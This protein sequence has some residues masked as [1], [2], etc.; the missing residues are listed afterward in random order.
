MTK[1]LVLGAGGAIASHVID[2]LE[3]ESDIELTLFA[4]SK[5]SLSGYNSINT[6]VG[7]VLDKEDL[8]GAIKGHDI[9]YANLSGA[10][11]SMAQIIVDTMEKVNV[12]RLIFV[13]SL[14]IYNEIPGKFGEWN[15]RMIGGALK[16]YRRAADIIE[17][18]SLDYTVVRPAWLTNYNEI[19]YE[20]TQKGEDFKGTEV[21]RKSVGAYISDII[22]NPNKDSKSS[23]GV[24]KPGTEADKP[25]F[26]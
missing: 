15:N 20:T 21:S 2:Q 14:G 13:T 10:V 11:D 25:S 9:V 17:N 24:N 4:R 26:Y 1:V 3:N 8:E 22:K 16:A 12:E 18:S 5:G 6:I 7:D 19:D 23:V